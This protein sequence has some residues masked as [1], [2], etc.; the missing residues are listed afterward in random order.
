MKMLLVLLIDSWMF[1]CH[2]SSDKLKRLPAPETSSSN[3]LYLKHAAL[4]T[5]ALV[6]CCSQRGVMA[7]RQC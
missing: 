2:N 1:L 3:L 7:F 6:V 4:Q 5:Q